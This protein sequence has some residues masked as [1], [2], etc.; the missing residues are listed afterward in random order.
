MPHDPHSVLIRRALPAD[1]AA[2]TRVRVATWKSAYAGLV[3]AAFLD[4]MH[5]DDPIA[6]ARMTARVAP[7]A[8]TRGFVAAVD[9]AVVGFVTAGPE[10]DHPRAH[11]ARELH[12]QRAEVFA[13]YVL[14]QHQGRGIG[15]RLLDTAGG[16]LRRTGATEY[17]LW[18]L[19]GNVA[20]RD[21]YAR[22]GLTETGRRQEIDLGGI[23]DE[24]EYR[25][26][27]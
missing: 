18:V 24:R 19:D 22:H 3:P 5:S 20:A 14:P 7:D 2:I 13:V 15:R 17:V 16:W 27:L 6:V 26:V 11:P 23:V 21:F 9:G 8:P 4:D 10:R 1:A 25:L 12:P